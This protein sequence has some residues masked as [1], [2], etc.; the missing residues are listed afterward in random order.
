MSALDQMMVPIYANLVRSGKR[1]LDAVP[2]LLRAAVQEA[3]A[4]SPGEAERSEG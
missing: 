1:E 2:E 3:L 4:S